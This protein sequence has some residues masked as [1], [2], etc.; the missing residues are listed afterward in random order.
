MDPETWP[1]GAA[2]FLHS[3]LPM[4]TT[5]LALESKP[6]TFGLIGTFAGFIGLLS[7][8]VGPVVRD[9]ITPQP[10][11]EKQLA[12]TIVSLKQHITAKIKKTPL[13][14]EAPRKG[15]S[16][17]NLPLDLSLVLAAVAIIGGAI[18]YLRREDRRYAYVAC[19]IGTA[20]LLWH[21]LLLALAV[22]VLCVILLKILPDALI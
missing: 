9:A 18:S 13:P 3:N 21:A 11:A 6:R 20:T 22:A 7:A 2:C 19:G 17:R 5:A 1:A 15:L 10:P 4:T 12:E 14:P 8:L 16:E